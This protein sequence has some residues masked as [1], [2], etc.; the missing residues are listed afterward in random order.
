MRTISVLFFVFALFALS[1]VA[2]AAPMFTWNGQ[3]FNSRAQAEAAMRQANAGSGGDDLY[4]CGD[5]DTTTLP[6]STIYNY[7]VDTKAPAGPIRGGFWAG[8]YYG[9]STFGCAP[10]AAPANPGL[11]SGSYPPC[12]TGTEQ[13]LYS[14]FKTWYYQAYGGQCDLE[15]PTI[16]G[17]YSLPGNWSGT[18]PDNETFKYENN[19]PSG[20]RGFRIRWKVRINSN[21]CDTAYSENEAYIGREFA[22]KCPNG[23]QVRHPPEV[24]WPKICKAFPSNTQIYESNPGQTPSDPPSVNSCPATGAPCVP[25]TGEKLLFEKDFD[26]SG[27]T[28][29]RTYRSMRSV[30]NRIHLSQRW[31][32]DWAAR[33]TIPSSTAVRR[34]DS[35][36]DLEQYNQVSGSTTHYKPVRSSGRYLEKQPDNSWVLVD[37]DGPDELYSATGQ[38]MSIRDDANPARSLTFTYDTA[39][40]LATATSGTGRALLFAYKDGYYTDPS[41]ALG[42]NPDRLIRIDNDAGQALATYGYSSAGLL[43]SVQHLDGT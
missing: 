16:I 37:Q 32:H 41:N 31:L 35:R 25:A 29:G 36:G 24:S 23:Y 15:D 9:S 28:F 10:T 20:R 18:Q 12:H 21:Q 8:W 17:G 34:Y 26:W 38:L 7:C 11:L 33:L 3:N 2:Q 13:E 4:L 19:A 42:W 40:R 30:D 1:E 5:I 14:K 22:Y 39:G 27:Y 43:S 6:G